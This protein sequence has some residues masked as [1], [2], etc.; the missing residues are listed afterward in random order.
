L[1]ST[2]SAEINQRRPGLSV[3]NDAVLPIKFVIR[4]AKSTDNLAA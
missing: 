4:L 2:V 3:S 1:S